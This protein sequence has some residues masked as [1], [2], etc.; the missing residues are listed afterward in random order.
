MKRRAVYLVI[1]VW[2]LAMVAL[3][4]LNMMTPLANAQE[5]QQTPMS[6]RPEHDGGEAPAGSNTAEWTVSEPAF[7]SNYPLGFT[8]TIKASSSG[9]AIE[10]ARVEW[11]HRPNTR[12]D[13]PTFVRRADAVY[14]PDTGTFTANWQ[15]TGATRTPPWVAVYYTWEFRDEAGNEFSSEELFTEY[16]DTSHIWT[17]TES[18]EVIVF[19]TGIDENAGDLVAQ[20]MADQRQKYYDGWGELL[21]FRPRV[22]LFGDYYTWLEW[23]TGYQ[24][25]SGLGVIAV[26]FTSDVWGGTTQ[27]LF[28]E[29]PR[30]LAYSTVLHEVEHMYQAEFLAGRTVF[31]PGW[32]IEGDATFYQEDDKAYAVNYVNNLIWADDLPVLLEG[33]G[34]TIDGADALHGYYMGYM[35]FKWF[36]DLYGIDMHRQIMALL[37]ENVPFTDA[38][39]Q[40]FGMNTTEIESAW[41]TWLGASPDVPTLIPTWTP[42]FPVIVTPEP[43]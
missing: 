8:F 25:T 39:E 41:R 4:A 3:V 2:L 16:E 38:L 24:D 11:V 14:D 6:E 29:T 10:R 37:A 7:I 17:R 27:V 32:F 35:F 43:Q 23:Q 20:A 21:P 33:T 13:E 40:M 28:N 12:P 42:A 9:G 36:T 1:P 34:P 18:D 5:L 19:S 31:T 26:G 30:E 15:P 22:I